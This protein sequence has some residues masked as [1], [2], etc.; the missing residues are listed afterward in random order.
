MA[1]L[2]AK[3]R[4]TVDIDAFV[5]ETFLRQDVL[6]LP[7]TAGI[8]LRA[9][10]LLDFHGDPAD[11]ILVATALENDVTFITRDE[12][13]LRFAKKSGGTLRVIEA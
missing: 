4:I 8:G 5:R 2:V 12:K 1:M 10:R 6:E 3:G 9:A 7:V 11:R 13:I